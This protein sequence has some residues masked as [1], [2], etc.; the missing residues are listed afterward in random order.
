MKID[1]FSCEY[2]VI[3]LF[4]IRNYCQRSNWGQQVA[5]DTQLTTIVLILVTNYC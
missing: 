2:L 3:K 5:A 4:K 1:T